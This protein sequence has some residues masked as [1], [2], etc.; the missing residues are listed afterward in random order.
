MYVSN[1]AELNFFFHLYVW[2]KIKNPIQKIPMPII[3]MYT[4][5][6]KKQIMFYDVKN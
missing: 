4:I 2:Y 1:V 6:K 5:K 3:Y